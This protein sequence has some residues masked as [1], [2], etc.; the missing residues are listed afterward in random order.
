[1]RKNNR[2][3]LAEVGTT[4]ISYNITARSDVS[5]NIQDKL[6]DAVVSGFYLDSINWYGNDEFSINGYPST[7]YGNFSTTNIQVGFPVRGPTLRPSSPV[8]NVTDSTPLMPTNDRSSNGS[9]DSNKG[10]NQKFDHSICTLKFDVL[11]SMNSMSSNII[12]SKKL[13]YDL[14]YHYH[15]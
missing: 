5:Q 6:N 13:V 10:K 9:S 3:S 11:R 2:R 14:I 8:S 4:T 12:I 15:Y 1:M 7:V